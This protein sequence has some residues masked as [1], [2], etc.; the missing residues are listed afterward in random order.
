M[1]NRKKLR[2]LNLARLKEKTG[3]S[4]KEIAENVDTDPNYLSA[5]AS[6]N[7]T[8]SIGDDVVERLEKFYELDQG[9]FGADNSSNVSEVSEDYKIGKVPVISSVEAGS[10]NEAVDQFTKGN[11]FDNVPCPFPHSTNTFALKVQGLSMTSD[12][13]PSFPEGCIIFADPDQAHKAR[14][15]SFV[16]AKLSKSDNVTFKQLIDDGLDRFL[17]PLNDSGYKT[18]HDNFTIL[19]KIIGKIEEF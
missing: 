12:R 14:N 4:W 16:L 15:G 17:K 5:A 19:A 13:D 11:G 2:K 1:N 9:W 3:H 8:R 10:W 7:N 6:Q 18:I